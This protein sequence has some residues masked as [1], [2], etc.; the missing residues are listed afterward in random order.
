[1]IVRK[2]DR[3][4]S[5]SN[6]ELP[7]NRSKRFQILVTAHENRW[8]NLFQVNTEPTCTRRE[9]N[10]CHCVKPE[11]FYGLSTDAVLSRF[12]R[13]SQLNGL[14]IDYFCL[15]GTLNK[16]LWVLE[17][18]LLCERVNILLQNICKY[19]VFE[20]RK[21]SSPEDHSQKLYG[22][23]GHHF[24][25]NAVSRHSKG[26]QIMQEGQSVRIWFCS[27]RSRLQII[28]CWPFGVL[29]HVL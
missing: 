7:L 19:V 27:C 24:F 22:S 20:Y 29:L 8:K 2:D 5:V 25:F 26:W 12:R 1:M 16:I 9:T 4:Q 11:Y 17:N 14:K 15:S 18:Q 23:L 13:R 3:A 10:F 21:L 28:F 6:L